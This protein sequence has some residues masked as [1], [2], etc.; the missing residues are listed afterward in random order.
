MELS[1]RSIIIPLTD[2]LIISFCRHMK[3]EFIKEIDGVSY[4]KIPHKH[5]CKL[6]I[7]AASWKAGNFKVG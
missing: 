2:F 3:Y 7:N 6:H 5:L 1:V 4:F